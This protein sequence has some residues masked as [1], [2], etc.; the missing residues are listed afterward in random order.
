APLD[1]ER[2]AYSPRGDP[3]EAAKEG[4]KLVDFDTLLATS[5]FLTINCPLTPETRGMIGAAEL[6]RLKPTAFLINTGR[7][8]IVDERALTEALKARRIAGAALDVFEQEPTPK[9]NPLLALDNV[10]VSPH[11][12]CWTDECFRLCAQSALGAIAD[13]AQG[14]KPAYPVNPEAMDHPRWR[15]FRFI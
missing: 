2:I 7:G 12:L 3:A 10:I 15:D 4:V 1:V 11:S 13:V 9:D 14:R 5:D 8:P 6:A